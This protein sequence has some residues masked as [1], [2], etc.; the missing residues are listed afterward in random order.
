MKKKLKLAVTLVNRVLYLQLN[1]IDHCTNVQLLD[2]PLVH[3]TSMH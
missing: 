3:L 2:K 1:Y